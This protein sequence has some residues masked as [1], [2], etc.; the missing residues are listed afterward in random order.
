MGKT[1]SDHCSEHSR[2]NEES[3]RGRSLMNT[4]IEGGQGGRKYGVRL[5]T[6]VGQNRRFLKSS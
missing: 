3:P 2:D 4:E 6:V 1:D 5:E